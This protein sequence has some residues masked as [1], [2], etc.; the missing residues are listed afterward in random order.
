MAMPNG[1]ALFRIHFRVPSS[2]DHRDLDQ[3]RGVVWTWLHLGGIGRR[4]NRGFGSLLWRPEG[5]QTPGSTSLLAGFVELEPT[6]D[7]A[8]RRALELYL[9]RGLA[10]VATVFEAREPKAALEATNG[11]T[12]PSLY[13]IDQVLVGRPLERDGRQLRFTG[14]GGTLESLIHGVGPNRLKGGEVTQKQLDVI[15]KHFGKAF[16]GRRPSPIRWRLFP[17][18]AGLVP[19]MV[20]FP[21]DG[22]VH[23]PKSDPRQIYDALGPDGL[24]FDESLLRAHLGTTPSAAPENAVATSLW[25]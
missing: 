5:E 4:S 14:D 23:L 21:V 3:L 17:T 15:R 10:K 6:R 9:L 11:R 25:R 1:G 7:L 18:P 16:D 13:S 19:V 22:E 12:W 8:D 24:G 20:W 2:L